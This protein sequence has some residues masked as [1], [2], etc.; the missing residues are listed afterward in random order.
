MQR[1]IHQNAGDWPW[2]ATIA[3]AAGA[4]ALLGMAALVAAY[5]PA[6]RAS[7]V[8]PIEALRHE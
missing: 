5:F 7:S 3:F 6:W 2:C 4:V 1:A 8:N